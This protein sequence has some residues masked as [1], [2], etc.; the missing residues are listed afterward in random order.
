MNSITL[1]SSIAW[2]PRKCIIVD[3]HLAFVISFCRDHPD[4]LTDREEDG[5]DAIYGRL[6]GGVR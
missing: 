3:Q 5:L 1:S 6:R 4:E 2:P